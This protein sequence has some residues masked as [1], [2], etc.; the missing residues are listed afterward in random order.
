MV[1][2][3]D[4]RTSENGFVIYL[5]LSIKVWLITMNYRIKYLIIMKGRRNKLSNKW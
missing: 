3:F 5:I 4:G 2:L 1:D